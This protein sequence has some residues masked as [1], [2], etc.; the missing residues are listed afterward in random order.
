MQEKDLSVPPNCNGFGRIRHFRRYISDG[1]GEDPIPIDPCLRALGLDTLD[2]LE[3]QVFQIA[4]C[5]LDCWYC[6][7][8]NDLKE[9]KVSQ[10]KWFRCDEMIDMFL[11]EKS[12]I[13]IIDLSG[14]NPELVPEWIVQ[15]M[16]ALE[17]KG[18]HE[19]I[20]LWSDDALVTD[21]TFRY[22][23][24]SELKYM[25]KYRNYGKVCCF[26]G[27]SENTFSYNAMIPC[28]YYDK[29]FDLFARYMELNLDLYGYVTFT[30]NNIDN[31]NEDMNR[32]VSKL[33]KIHP[34]LPLRIVPLKIIEFTPV[35]ERMNLSYELALENQE[36]VYEAWIQELNASYN[37]EL[38]HK[39]ICD[40]SLY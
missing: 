20:Y 30:T 28:S 7:V 35:K 19:S 40:I 22:L 36:L 12:N 5:N 18:L 15:T 1:W 17:K 8:P 23:N 10:S 31:L 24:S 32:F 27:Y 26:K 39:S 13:R 21:Y 29:Q 2:I 34:L 6:F 38:L 11:S 14:G 37:T 9:A 25:Q 3:T 33:K 4:S 16:K